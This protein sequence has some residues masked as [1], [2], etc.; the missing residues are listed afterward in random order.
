M[1]SSEL[2]SYAVFDQKYDVIGLDQLPILSK[3]VKIKFLKII[4]F[5]V[6]SFSQKKFKIVTSCMVRTEFKDF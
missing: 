1:T 5:V 3:M 6:K 2:L 4:E